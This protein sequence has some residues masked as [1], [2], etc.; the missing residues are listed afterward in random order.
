MYQPGWEGFWG[1]KDTCICMTESLH[2]SP[3]IITILL[4]GSTPIQ[5]VF[6]VKKRI[7]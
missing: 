1:R 3:E 4:I 2:Y 5:N 7:K 6:G